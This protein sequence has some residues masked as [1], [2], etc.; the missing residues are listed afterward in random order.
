MIGMLLQWSSAKCALH[1]EREG[2]GRGMDG[3]RDGGREAERERKDGM[4][5]LKGFNSP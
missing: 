1:R 3:G 4:Q 2:G 5:Y